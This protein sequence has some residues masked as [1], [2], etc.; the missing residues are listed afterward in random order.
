MFEP[1]LSKVSK[2]I[3]ILNQRVCMGKARIGLIYIILCVT[4]I[5][6]VFSVINITFIIFILS[7]TFIISVTYKYLRCVY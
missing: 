4:C 6:S 1:F 5:I 3:V 7:I 2:G